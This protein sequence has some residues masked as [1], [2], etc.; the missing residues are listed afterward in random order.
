MR[1]IT[2]S[3]GVQASSRRAAAGA[4]WQPQTLWE[5]Y[6]QHVMGSAPEQGYLSAFWRHYHGSSA[7]MHVHG[8]DL[9]RWSS[10]CDGVLCRLPYTP[11]SD[12]LRELKAL[13][14]HAHRVGAAV[15]VIAD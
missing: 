4:V 3:S 7:E 8:Q 10:E 12:F 14:T 2:L 11:L 5:S 1:C 6:Y 9:L 15:Q 13:C